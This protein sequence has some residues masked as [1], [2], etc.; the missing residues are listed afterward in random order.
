MSDET[1]RVWLVERTFVRDELG[2]VS[3]VYATP[4]GERYYRRQISASGHTGAGADVT[5]EVATAD[6]QPVDDEETV[7]RYAGEV[8]RM[9]DQHDPDE[10]V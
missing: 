7:E 5:R 6:L 9:R 4:D 2:L 10:T 1:T 3:L 8:D